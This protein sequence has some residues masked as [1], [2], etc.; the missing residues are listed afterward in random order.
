MILRWAIL[1]ATLHMNTLLFATEQLPVVQF[2]QNGKLLTFHGKLINGGYVFNPTS[3]KSVQIATLDWPPYISDAPC[4][5]GWAF[6]L[7]VATLLSQGYKVTLKFLPWSRAVREVESGRSDILYPEYYIEKTAPSD[8]YPGIFRISLLALSDTFPGGNIALMKRRDD[9]EVFFGELENIRG[10]KIG[11]VRG[12]QNTPEFDAMLDKGLFQEFEA[13][14]DLQLI[15]LLLGKRVDLIIGDPK[16]F[17]YTLYHS[18]MSNTA[19]KK[20]QST[21]EEVKPALKYN[22]LYFAVSRKK[23]HWQTLLGD[24]NS[25][26]ARLEIN[27]DIERMKREGGS[28]R[29]IE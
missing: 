2:Q 9:P 4:Q 22:P 15:K 20:A 18:D 27:G 12:Y 8:H 26:L 5:K 13:K 7:A 19:I 16:V 11:V 1:L 17:R 10:M 24:I 3:Q 25:A 23:P 6:D 14:D 28:C 21:L 29:P